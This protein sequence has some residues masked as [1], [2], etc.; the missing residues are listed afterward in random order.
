M[1]RGAPSLGP[2]TSSS[3]STDFR[4][5]RG[6]NSHGWLRVPSSRQRGGGWVQDHALLGRVNLLAATPLCGHDARW[7]VV[8]CLW[9]EVAGMRT[10]VAIRLCGAALYA[11]G[12]L[13]T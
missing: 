6:R 10:D 8:G 3:G 7:W 13:L 2:R 12:I 4:P 1:T 9:T 11:R 5:C